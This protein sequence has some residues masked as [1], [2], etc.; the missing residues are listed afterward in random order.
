MNIHGDDDAFPNRDEDGVPL[1]GMTLRTY[2]ATHVMAG[3]AA[4]PEV[5]MDAEEYA[6]WAV[7]RADALIRRLRSQ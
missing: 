7:S 5:S 6:D 4:C 1:P 2:I 3:L